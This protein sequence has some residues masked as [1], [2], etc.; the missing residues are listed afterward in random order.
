MFT[1]E[2]W[3]NVEKDQGSEETGTRPQCSSQD[4]LKSATTSTHSFPV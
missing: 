4:E 3:C 1:Y 2:Y